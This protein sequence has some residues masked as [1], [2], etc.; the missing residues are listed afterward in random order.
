MRRSAA[1]VDDT[2]R[3]VLANARI[4]GCNLYLPPG[5]LDRK[6]YL[7]VNAQLEAMGGKWNRRAKAHVF[8]ANPTEALT[9]LLDGGTIAAAP[10][11]LEAFFATPSALANKIVTESDIVDLEP[12][13]RVLEPSA[14]D[15]A[16]VRAILD[17]NPDVH[18]TAVEPNAV[19]AKA[20]GVDPRVT[21]ITTTLEQFAAAA[22]SQ[23]WTAAVMNPPFALPGKP[24]IWIDHVRTVWNMLADGGQLLAIVPAGF[25][26][27]RDRKHTAIRQ[28]ILTYGGYQELPDDAFASSGTG[29]RTVLAYAHRPEITPEQPAMFLPLDLG[30]Q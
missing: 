7:A 4:E 2:V 9:A 10:K 15:G 28:L 21:V 3:E 17:A 27:R 18:V 5:Q 6:V 19:R 29:V 22:P 26:F 12:G 8:T 24:T 20:I 16:L 30:G 14:G 1:P 23:R 25:V 13:D 11:V